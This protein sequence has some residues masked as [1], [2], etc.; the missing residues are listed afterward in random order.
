MGCQASPFCR[1]RQKHGRHADTPCERGAVHGRCGAVLVVV[2]VCLTAAATM[3]I[4]VA[5]SAFMEKR[6]LDNSQWRLQAQWLAEAGVERA[7]ARLLADAK[8]SGETWAIAPQDL[9]GN[10][11]A[12]VRIRV[13]NVAG[14]PERRSVC[15]EAEYPGSGP[16]HCR[17]VKQVLVDRDA[18]R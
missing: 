13:E 2:L 4:L 8:Y 1:Q 17:Q 5:R 9:V 6:A 3:L 18:I 12:V 15:V 16:G 10:E 14:K 11:D 7:A